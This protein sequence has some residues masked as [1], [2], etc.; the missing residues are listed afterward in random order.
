TSCPP[1]PRDA[2]ALGLEQEIRARL[3]AM[4]ESERK[5]AIDQAFTERNEAVIGAVLRGPAMLV[6]MSPARHDVVRARYQREFHGIDLA[7]RERITKALDA[8]E[9]GGT[10]FMGIVRAAA[11]D[12]AA[13]VAAKRKEKRD[14]ALAAHSKEA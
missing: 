14:A 2:V 11:N 4:P 5:D 1:P 10:A 9:R 8:V 6:G 3:A 7:R 12:P 13:R